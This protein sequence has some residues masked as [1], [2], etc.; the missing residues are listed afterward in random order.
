MHGLNR[1]G[2]AHGGR[3]ARFEGSDGA[4]SGGRDHGRGHRG[5]IGHG[6]GGGHGRGRGGFGRDAAWGGPETGGPGGGRRR[7]KR[8]AGD[9]L[10]LLVLALLADGPRHGYELIRAF[11]EKSGDAYSPSPGVLY[12]LLTLL[13]DMER[14]AEVPSAGS[15]RRSYALTDAGRTELEAAK[16][17]VAALFAR[18]AAMA[19]DTARTDVAPVRRA[20]MNLRT[21]TMQRLSR[22]E[23]D[24]KLGFDIAALLDEAAQKIERL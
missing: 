21:A 23:S 15:T 6:F 7:G 16:E 19:E 10:R 12:P 9:E 13:E 24:S 18:L 14:V 3:R 8:F 5:E 22:E 11:A 17:Q 1:R 20:M 4:G 2:A